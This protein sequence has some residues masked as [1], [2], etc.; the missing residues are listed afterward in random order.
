MKS[1]G[2]LFPRG[3]LIVSCQALEDEPLHSPEIMA[4]MAV[5]AVTGGAA[6]I[7]A[8]SPP[9]I[10]AIRAAVHVPI[11]GIYKQVTAGSD[12]YITPTFASASEVAD[13]GADMIALD[14][15]PR[16]RV[17]PDQLDSLIARIHTE[18]DRPVMAD[19]STVDEGLAA[20]KLGAD[21]LSTTLSGYTPYSPKSE[22]PDYELL[23][24]LLSRSTVP[25]I[26][27]GRFHYPDQAAEALRLGA[28]AV[29]VGGA[30]TR[31]QEITRRFSDRI[32]KG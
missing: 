10:R 13:A 1:I 7:R 32:A 24:E 3:S 30:I 27:E 5:A 4:R 29:V 26:A 6:A 16:S 31:P 28:Y 22:G 14:A 17:G 9:D 23:R 12:V 8:N 2:Q 21:V 25:V 11:I 15:T 19:V 18:L 20:E